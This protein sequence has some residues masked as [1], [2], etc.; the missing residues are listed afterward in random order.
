MT[1]NAAP[2]IKQVD[3]LIHARWIIPVNAHRNILENH[4]LAIKNDSIIDILPTAEAKSRFVGCVAR[5]QPDRGFV[6]TC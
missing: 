2:R 3:S 4:S 5:Q 6:C 1:Q